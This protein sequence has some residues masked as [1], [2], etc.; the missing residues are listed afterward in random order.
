MDRSS[1]SRGFT[2]IELLVVIAIIAILIALLLP[3]VQQAREA[4]RRTQCRNHLK[5]LGL[6]LHNYHDNFN[7]LPAGEYRQSTTADKGNWTWSAMILPYMDQAPLYNQLQV[8]TLRVDQA[9]QNT[10]TRVLLQTPLPAFRCPSDVAPMLNT[11]AQ[12]L[13]Q[14]ANSTTTYPIATSNYVGVNS[15]GTPRPNFNAAISGANGPNANAN[16][17]FYR[18]SRVNFRDILDGTSNTFVIGERSWV[19]PFGATIVPSA[20]IVFAV[21]DGGGAVNGGIAA[22]LGTG[23][24]KLNCKDNIGE[25]RRAFTS[26][27]TGGAHFLFHDGTVKFISENIEHNTDDTTNA[28]VNPVNS[29]YEYY[30]AIQDG[31]TIG[32]N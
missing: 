11:D 31:Q 20:G 24:R 10:T 30:M 13:I 15:T 3:A 19:T 22:A 27:H 7:G 4:A 21:Q 26:N 32:G 6:A 29:V 1:R 16:G 17:T 25:C 5:Q 28:G 2:L 8:G 9:L 23:F 12:R 14:E 18:N